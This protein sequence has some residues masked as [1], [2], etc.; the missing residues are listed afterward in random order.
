MTD[1]EGQWSHCDFARSMAP[2]AGRHR[3]GNLPMRV[4]RTRRATSRTERKPDGSE[5]VERSEEESYEEQ[6]EPRR[7]VSRVLPRLRAPGGSSL[8][9]L[10][11]RISRTV[12]TLLLANCV[13]SLL[14][15]LTGLGG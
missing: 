6:D 10:I 12:G 7:S 14:G 9:R 5:I 1:N 4:K 13:K 3:E 8:R 15:W 2:L 11:G